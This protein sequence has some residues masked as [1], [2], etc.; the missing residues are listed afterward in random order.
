M[1]EIR[2]LNYWTTEGIVV[3]I[4]NIMIPEDFNLYEIDDK[5]MTGD[6]IYSF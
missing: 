4:N 1:I 2:D 6:L 3:A 5:L